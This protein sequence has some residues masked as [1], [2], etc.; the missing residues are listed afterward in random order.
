MDFR[1]GKVGSGGSDQCSV[2]PKPERS[3]GLPLNTHGF[4]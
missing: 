3:Q 2:G 1:Q 4:P